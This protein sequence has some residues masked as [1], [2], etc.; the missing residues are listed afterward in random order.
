MSTH[1]YDDLGAYAL[2]ALEPGERLGV[3][4]HVE[5]C[6]ECRGELHE[7]RAM[8]RLLGDLP[9][10]ALLEGPPEDADLLLQR[11]LGRVRTERRREVVRRRWSIGAAASVA[12]VA[13]AGGGIVLGRSTLDTTVV[14][15]PVTT[16]TAPGTE[17]LNASDATTG[18]SLAARV[19]PAAGWVRVSV[20]V[21]GVPAGTRCRIIVVGTNGRREVAGSWLVSPKGAAD[22]T[23]LEG[24]AIVDP[25]Q[26]AAIIIESIDGKQLVSAQRT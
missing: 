2:D 17:V 26:V 21:R 15:P 11:T 23:T 14:S 19:V 3:E 16:T 10:E 8:S 18:A 9:P 22:G 20:Q 5:R 6:E 4:S 24:S 1:P 13:L 12:A 7:L 25:D